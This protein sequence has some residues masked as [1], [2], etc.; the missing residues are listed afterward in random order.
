MT[1]V[2]WPTSLKDSLCGSP[3]ETF[4]KP[5]FIGPVSE[6]DGNPGKAV[7]VLESYFSYHR[8]QLASS[9]LSPEL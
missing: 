2:A 5:C 9:L 3:E 6:K 7:P 8:P 4:A 1:D